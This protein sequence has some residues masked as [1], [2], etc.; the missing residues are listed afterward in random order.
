L[1]F[2]DHPTIINTMFRWSSFAAVRAGTGR[3]GDQVP[4]P[5][6]P[7][8][9]G[10][11]APLRLAGRRRGRKRRMLFGL[12]VFVFGAMH[13]PAAAHPPFVVALY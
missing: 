13:R 8:G 4:A 12:A 5:S 7:V 6:R 1:I 3:P 11:A 2:F 10:P 9:A